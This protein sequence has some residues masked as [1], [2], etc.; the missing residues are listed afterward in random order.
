MRSFDFPLSGVIPQDHGYYLFAGL[1]SLLPELHG[2]RGFQ[3]APVRGTRRRDGN[4]LLDHKSILNVRGITAEEALRIQHTA[5]EIPTGTVLIGAASIREH[6]G[7]SVLASRQVVLR[8]ILDKETFEKALLEALPSGVESSVGREH[9]TILPERSGK[10]RQV[11]RG[12]SVRLSG[13]TEEQSLD[14]QSRGIGW[15]RQMGCGVFY[16][17]RYTR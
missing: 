1:C 17:P 16:S 2:R 15:E 12:W 13:L 11:M 10:P 5:F 8:G 14:I 3:V 7:G 9:V 4:L 6:R